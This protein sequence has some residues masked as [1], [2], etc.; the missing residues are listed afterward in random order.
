MS[1]RRVGVAAA[2]IISAQV[3]SG[4]LASAWPVGALTAPARAAAQT[5]EGTVTDAD[6]DRPIADA[7]VLLVDTLSVTVGSTATDDGGRFRLDAPGPGSFILFVEIK[8]YL[9]Y[10]DFVTLATGE[11]ATRQIEMPLISARAARVMHDVIQ[12]ESAF[13]LP[14]EELCSEPVRP[15]EAGVLVGVTR[16]RASL[17]AIPRAVVRLEPVVDEGGE[18]DAPPP[19]GETE[20]GAW[21]RSR[22]A[23]PT[24]A[25]W[26]CNVPVGRARIVARA[27][28]FG[29]DTSYATIRAGTISWYDALL[30]P[31][32]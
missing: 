10:S 19:D 12:R 7:A 2:V 1:A 20:S 3:V 32:Q 22:I 31:R 14:W 6:Y 16:D 28:G 27:D 24:G 26:F 17:D 5:V 18:T 25:F 21:P 29:A 23:T 15:W 4:I 9:S 30:R 11:N 8:G 13:Q